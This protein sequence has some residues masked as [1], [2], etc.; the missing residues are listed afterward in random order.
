MVTVALAVLFGGYQL[1]QYGLSQVNGCN[2][3]FLDILWPGR[4]TGCNPDSG[5]SI[6]VTQSQFQKLLQN[7]QFGQ[8]T[9]SSSKG[10]CGKGYTAVVVIGK[11]GQGDIKCIKN[12]STPGQ[13]GGPPASA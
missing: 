12:G 3:G 1:F 11:N 6:S 13:P 7:A 5:A 10:Q 9:P 4:F 8:L 2:A